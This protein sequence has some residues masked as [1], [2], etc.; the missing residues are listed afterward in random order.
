[1][2]VEVSEVRSQRSEVG[3]PKPKP[4][5]IGTIRH[6]KWFN[7]VYVRRLRWGALIAVLITVGVNEWVKHPEPDAP[8][9]KPTAEQQMID[10]SSRSTVTGIVVVPQ[11]SEF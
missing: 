8:D 10:V 11:G 6:T 7:V 2:T 1:M 9:S 5:F 3:H 4:V